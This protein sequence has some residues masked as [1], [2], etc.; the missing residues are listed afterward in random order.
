ME[1]DGIGLQAVFVSRSVRDYP[2]A[3]MY[4]S[5]PHCSPFP[6]L[7]FSLFVKWKPNKVRWLET[8]LGC[9][10][11]RHMLRKTCAR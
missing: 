8:R 3:A 10:G 5:L 2:R 11:G 6:I 1:R 9:G 4:A 7:S